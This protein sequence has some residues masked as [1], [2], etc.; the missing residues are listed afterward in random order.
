MSF[1]VPYETRSISVLVGGSHALSTDPKPAQYANITVSMF[2][3]EECIAFTF[4]C[5][6]GERGGAWNLESERYERTV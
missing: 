2:H 3:P 4:V 6:L 5:S 1:R